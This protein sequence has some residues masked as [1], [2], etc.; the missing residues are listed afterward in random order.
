MLAQTDAFI[1]S[2]GRSPIIQTTKSLLEQY[3]DIIPLSDLSK[4]FREAI[5]VCRSLEIQFLWIDSLCIIQDDPLDWEE[6]SAKMADVYSGSHLNLA[7]A[8]ASDGTEGLFFQRLERIKVRCKLSTGEHDDVFITNSPSSYFMDSRESPLASRAWAL[9]EKVLPPRTLIF[10]KDQLHW[11]CHEELKSESSRKNM[12]IDQSFSSSLRRYLSSE[13]EPSEEISAQ[14]KLWYKMLEAYTRCDLTKSEDKLPALA[15]LANAFSRRSGFSYTAGIWEQDLEMGLLWKSL[16][17]KETQLPPSYRAPTWSWAALDTKVRYLR[18]VRKANMSYTFVQ[19]LRLETFQ[20]DEDVF[21]VAVQETK[22]LLTGRLRNVVLLADF[23]TETA[24]PWKLM[25]GQHHVGYATTDTY[26]SPWKIAN[27]GTYCLPIL[28]L[29]TA[30]T[31]DDRK[32]LFEIHVLI[33]AAKE[34][35]DMY[36]TIGMG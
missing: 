25:I 3:K 4:T 2:G 15:G 9:Q 17:P 5:L 23:E 21:G 32:N 26:Y 19:N 33:L 16:F 6:E 31:A 14:C 1:F 35:S 29:V 8:A 18:N 22:L 28:K 13:P 10:G 12:Q 11:E 30:N 24:Y 34:E 36:E 20:G 7:A 27:V